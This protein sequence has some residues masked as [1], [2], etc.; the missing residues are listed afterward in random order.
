MK[1]LFLF[2]LIKFLFAVRHYDKIRGPVVGILTVPT[3]K[4]NLTFSSSSFSM[5]PGSYVKWLE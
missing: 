3:S 5:I 4:S 2:L 1:I